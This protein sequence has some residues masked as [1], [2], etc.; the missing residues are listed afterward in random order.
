MSGHG[1]IQRPRPILFYTTATADFLYCAAAT[2]DLR[3]R[4]ICGYGLSTATAE[5][6]FILLS[7]IITPRTA[8]TADCAKISKQF[9][10]SR[11][12]AATA[13]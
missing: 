8:A 10:V 2:A 7:L 11:V 3:P 1:Q 6:L 12:S 9:T 5:Q 4:P 13:E